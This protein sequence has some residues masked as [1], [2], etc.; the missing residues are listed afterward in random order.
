ML[1]GVKGW[2]QQKLPQ[3]STYFTII[4]EQQGLYRVGN[5]R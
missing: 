5:K 4:Q 1:H 3:L 2:P